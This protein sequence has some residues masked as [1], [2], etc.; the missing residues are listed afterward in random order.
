MAVGAAQRPKPASRSALRHGSPSGD[1]LPGPGGRVPGAGVVCANLVV[2]FECAC[3]IIYCVLQSVVFLVASRIS[4]RGPGLRSSTL[5]EPP[6][7]SVAQ[8]CCSCIPYRGGGPISLNGWVLGGGG[9]CCIAHGREAVCGDVRGYVRR[10][11]RGFGGGQRSRRAWISSARWC[12]GGAYPTA[13]VMIVVIRLPRPPPR[14][15]RVRSSPRVTRWLRNRN[16]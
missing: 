13:S 4:G 11:A 8:A 5:C 2:L 7:F 14:R 15:C 3:G 16:Q 12:S 6:R 1:R 10:V 9:A